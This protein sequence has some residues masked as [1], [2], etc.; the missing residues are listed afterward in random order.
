ME[1]V[2]SICCGLDVH[3]KTVVACLIKEGQKDFR[4]FSTMTSD[5]LKLKEWLTAAGCLKVGIESTGV[6]W[7][8]V[9]N[10]LEDAIEV[11]LL[12]AR[13]VKGR[14]GRKTDM[15]DCEWIAEMVQ[16][17]L[18]EGSFIPPANIREL[19]ELTRYRST[20]VRE[21]AMLVNRVQKVLES[22]NIKLSSVLT[23]I[24]GVSGRARVTRSYRRK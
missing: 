9:F 3:A 10:I 7:R 1:V 17:G 20:F 15:R 11:A 12:N 8:P 22:A 19:R 13:D 2:H 4:T 16:Y 5:L 21:R 14:R 24:E 18:V 23:N 6:Y